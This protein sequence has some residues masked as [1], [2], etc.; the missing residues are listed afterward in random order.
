MAP[1]IKAVLLLCSLV[2]LT[3]GAKIL[4][5]PFGMVSHVMSLESIGR[6]LVARNHEVHILLSPSSP[7]LDQLKKK[8][9]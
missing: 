9:R 5:L 3:T 1:V 8:V 4:L 6:T 2:H 7:Y